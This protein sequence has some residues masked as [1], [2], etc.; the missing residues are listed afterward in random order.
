VAESP[1]VG[2]DDFPEQAVNKTTSA[3]MAISTAA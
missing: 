1:G 2:A 3:R